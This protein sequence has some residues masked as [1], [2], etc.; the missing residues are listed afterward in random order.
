MLRCKGFKVFLKEKQPLMISLNC[1]SYPIRQLIVG[2]FLTLR[3]CACSGE[4]LIVLILG[5]VQIQN[6]LIWFKRCVRRRRFTL[7]TFY[8]SCSVVHECIFKPQ[9]PLLVCWQHKYLSIARKL[10]F[11]YKWIRSNGYQ[12]KIR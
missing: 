8:L 12:Q 10:G 4:D 2:I 5:A 6:Q 1:Y 9:G 11:I 3:C 7:L